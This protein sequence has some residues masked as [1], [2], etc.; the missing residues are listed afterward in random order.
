VSR[1]RRQTLKYPVMSA[2]ADWR[3]DHQGGSAPLSALWK[4]ARFEEHIHAVKPCRHGASAPASKWRGHPGLVQVAASNPA[5][6]TPRRW[7]GPDHPAGRS[8]IEP[9]AVLMRSSE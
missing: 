8:A 5:A 6:S 9:V 4:V 7:T 2:Q 3:A 1:R